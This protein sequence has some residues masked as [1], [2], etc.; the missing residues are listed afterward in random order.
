MFR[1]FTDNGS[2]MVAAFIANN[3]EDDIAESDTDS[4]TLEKSEELFPDQDELDKGASSEVDNFHICGKDHQIAFVGWKR[5][6][7]T[8]AYS[9]TEH[10]IQLSGKKLVKNCPMK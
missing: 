7:A 5:F 8:P 6:E 2:D 3:N 4:V 9:R 1:I 10:P